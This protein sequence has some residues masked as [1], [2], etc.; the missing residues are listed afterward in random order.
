MNVQGLEFGLNIS[1][2]THS[3]RFFDNQT[4]NSATQ[5]GYYKAFYGMVRALTHNF[6]FTALPM[7]TVSLSP[8]LRSGSTTWNWLPGN[9]TSS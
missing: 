9:F 5:H 6:I 8:C 3:M 1:N 4:W 7:R 2:Y